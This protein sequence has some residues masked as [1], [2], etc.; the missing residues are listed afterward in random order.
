MDEARRDECVDAIN[1]YRRA[2]VVSMVVCSRTVEYESLTGKLHLS[3]AVVV[4]PL[5]QAQIDGYIADL[6]VHGETLAQMLADDSELR[7]L[8]YCQIDG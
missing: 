5:T 4:R 2:H 8:A 3:G 1:A 6:G 7:G